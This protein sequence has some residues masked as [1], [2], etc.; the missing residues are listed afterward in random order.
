MTVSTSDKP[1]HK[2]SFEAVFPGLQI[3]EQYRIPLELQGC[4]R[5]EYI[6]QTF[7]KP[8]ATDTEGETW[9]L[10]AA[11]GLCI[12]CRIDRTGGKDY[13]CFLGIA[14]WDSKKSV[15]N[16]HPLVTL[17]DVPQL[18][19]RGESTK[20]ENIAVSQKFVHEGIE[21]AIK[22]PNATKDRGRVTWI[23]N[24]V[25]LETDVERGSEVLE[26]KWVRLKDPLDAAHD[27]PSITIQSS[28]GTT[29]SQAGVEISLNAGS[30]F[31]KVTMNG[32]EVM[33]SMGVESETKIST[34]I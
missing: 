12:D 15:L 4:W 27:K 25:W 11:N 19:S 20:Q 18:M 22:N 5:R 29:T 31:G 34:E 1:Y 13:D 24:D 32:K 16:W 14:F 6:K 10:Q 21:K 23:D 7:R 3:P 8:R 33:F 28:T 17:T 30:Y 9:Y 26:E 2:G